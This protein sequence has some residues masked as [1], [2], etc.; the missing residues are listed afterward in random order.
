MII[1]QFRKYM[2]T[3]MVL[4]VAL[5]LVFFFIRFYNSDAS[6][7]LA[8]ASGLFISLGLILVQAFY[9]NKVMNKYNFFGKPGFLV[10]LLYLSFACFGISLDELSPI[11]ICNFIL[12]R[13]IDKLI[14]VYHREDA[15]S[16][17]FDMGMLVGIGSLIYYPFAAMLLPVWVG[18]R[19]FR[20]FYW[21]EWIAP[22]LGFLTV[23]FLVWVYCF[24]MGRVD[25][26]VAFWPS[27]F[28]F[29]LALNKAGIKN[30]L[31]WGSVVVILILFLN[32][33]RENIFKRVV[34]IRKIVQL[35]LIMLVTGLLAYVLDQQTEG[36]QF[37][38]ALPP[39]SIY[40]AYYFHFASTKWFYEIVYL[41]L[42]FT[43]LIFQIL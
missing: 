17:M 2:P 19:L 29:S 14:E 15:K 37:L 43:I 18:L 42:L 4:L 1:T 31:V 25:E 16:I 23:L 11:L 40:A 32:V 34:Q 33:L 3:N 8:S 22:V 26:F 27:E 7:E 36:S 41:F 21:R 13:M 24:W 28:Q 9:L 30:Y 12:I 5:G 39:L 6:L 20:P 35:L 38:L 10:A